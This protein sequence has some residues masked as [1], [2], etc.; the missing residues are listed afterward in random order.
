MSPK[1]L[2]VDNDQDMAAMLGRHLE[3]EGL[4]VT[5]V[6]SGQ[7]ALVALEQEEFGVV[8][9]DL[10]MD[11]VDGLTV[12]RRAQAAQPA[13]RVI[14]MTAFGSLENAI[15]AMRHGAYDYLTKPF[16]LAE[17]SLAVRRALDE[18]RLREENRRLRAEV[19][20]RYSF[21]NLLGRSPAMQ[22]VFEQ[23]RAVASSDA[24]VVLLGDS[25]TGKELV[26]RAIHWNSPRRDGPFVPVNCAAIPEA[27]LESELFGHVKGAFTGA[28]QNKAGLFEVA[29]KGTLF[30]DEVAELSP[31]LQVKLLRVIQEKTIRRVGGIGDRS[32]DVRILAATNK[33]LQEEVRAGRFREDLY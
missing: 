14:L 24:A 25:G 23:I 22:A 5:A 8:L 18:R 29:D 4:K 20:Q 21:E 28:V 12:L 11:E 1:V 33:N 10:R 17:V 9:T 3:A 27:L 32:V 31:P 15:E 30:L 7:A 6:T 13:T 19:A 16:K 2:V 26:G